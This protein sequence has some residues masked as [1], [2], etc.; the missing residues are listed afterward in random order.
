MR[1][2]VGR[3]RTFITILNSINTY[4]IPTNREDLY[5]NNVPWWVSLRE[6]NY[7][8]IRTLVAGETEELYDLKR[9]PEELVNLAH[10][11]RFHPQVLKYRKAMIQELKDVDAKFVH[12]LP[13]VGTGY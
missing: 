3:D 2:V 12:G 1:F 13:P 4:T 6:G 11:R 5:I 8:Y 10:R 9:D 7:K